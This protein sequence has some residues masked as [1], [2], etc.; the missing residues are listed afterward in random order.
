M[1]GMTNSLPLDEFHR[2]LDIL[3]TI[4][5][6]LVVLDHNYHVTLWNGFMENHS[7]YNLR[8]L[9]EHNIFHYFPELAEEWLRQKVEAVFTLRCASFISWELRPYLFNFAASRPFT[10]MSD[11]MYQ[12]VTIMPLISRHGDISHVC[13]IIYDVTDAATSKQ[14]LQEANQQ[15]TT[16]SITDRLTG[17]YN[18]GYWEECLRNEFNRYHRTGN[19]STL[20]MLD[21]DFFKKVNDSYGHTAGDEVLRQAS[22]ILHE[23][24][25]CSDIAGRYG[26]EE[27]GVLLININEKIAWHV[28]ER[29][30]QRIE[31]E[32]II[33]NEQPIYFT[34]S[35]GLSEIN[36]EHTT[37]LQWLQKA[38]SAL[39]HS[40]NNGR[41]QVTLASKI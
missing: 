25:R 28:A 22:A 38:D 41:N 18:R 32:C 27:F 6:G 23:M 16:L 31:K 29:L 26:G 1:T 33:F 19:V 40:K 11:V 36:P 39:Y 3:Q 34:I 20:M 24:V 30:R 12:N 5:V 13:I 9:E 14:A 2:I 4:D 35:I 8:Q 37:A 15:L 7:G 21:I 10:G 17:L